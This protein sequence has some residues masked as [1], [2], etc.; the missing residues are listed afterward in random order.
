MC[1]LHDWCTLNDPHAA[2]GSRSDRVL[3]RELTAGA[4]GSVGQGAKKA[5]GGGCGVGGGG[6]LMGGKGGGLSVGVVRYRGG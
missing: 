2:H 1:I 4:H 5:G 3:M 6:D